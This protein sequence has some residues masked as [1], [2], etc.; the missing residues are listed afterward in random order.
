[1]PQPNPRLEPEV[2]TYLLTWTTYGTWLPG[3]ERGW[4]KPGNGWQQPDPRVQQRAESRMTESACLL[5]LDQRKIV[6]QTITRHCELRGW[7]LHTVN[8]RS[9]HVHVV[10][11]STQPPVIVRDQLKAWC[12]RMLK[13]HQKTNNPQQLMRQKWWTEGGS[14]RIIDDEDSL[15][16]AIYYVREAQDRKARDV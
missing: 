5:D 6:E 16:R 4:V 11:S 2:Y 10:V 7:L 12:T 3:D 8:C 13:E 14:Q 15:E 9:N 1:M